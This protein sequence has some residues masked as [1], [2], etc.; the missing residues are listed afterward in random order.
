[1]AAMPPLTFVLHENTEYDVHC[2]LCRGDIE[3]EELYMAAKLF[4]ADV[5][6]MNDALE[7]EC[8]ACDKDSRCVECFW[9]SY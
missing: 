1:M 4:R 6:F 5:I 7:N 8:P 3:I 2:D 9:C